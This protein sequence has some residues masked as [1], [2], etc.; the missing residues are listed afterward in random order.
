MEP[1]PI[2]GQPPTEAERPGHVARR[3]DGVLLSAGGSTASADGAALGL[4]ALHHRGRC[5]VRALRV[6]QLRHRLPAT[7][8]GLPRRALGRDRA[9]PVGYAYECRG[10]QPILLRL[11]APTSDTVC[12]V[13]SWRQQQFHFSNRRSPPLDHISGLSWPHRQFLHWP[14]HVSARQPH[15]SAARPNRCSCS[16]PSAPSFGLTTRL[17]GLPTRPMPSTSVHLRPFLRQLPGQPSRISLRSAPSSTQ[18]SLTL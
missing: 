10:C 2:R 4:P 9:Q 7:S 16:G 18:L 14:Q 6:A 11:Q 13:F 15:V 1:R 3:V 17:L 5:H 12:R 8:G